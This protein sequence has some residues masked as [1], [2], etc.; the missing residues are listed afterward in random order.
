VNQVEFR[1]VTDLEA[2]TLRTLEA[3][4]DEVRAWLTEALEPYRS[5][6]ITE[7]AISDG[8]AARAKINRLSKA[9]SDQRIAVKKRYLE[10]Y[11][12][13][14]AKAK[15]LCAICD[16]ASGHIDTQIKEI[17]ERRKQE[18]LEGL[19]AYF[20]ERADQAEG[21]LTWDDVFNPKWGNAGFGAE[22]AQKEIE[23][24][25]S[26]CEADMA[27]IREMD[28]PHQAALIAHY[29]ATHDI[30]AVIRKDA[31]LKRVEAAE[32]ERRAAQE[33]ARREAESRRAEQERMER[34]RSA[35]QAEEETVEI[36]MVVDEEDDTPPLDVDE[37][38]KEPEK[39][40]NQVDFRVWA[41][42]AQLGLL[43]RFLRENGIKYGRV[44]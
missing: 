42:D 15:E 8:K 25:I 20:Q 35:A 44:I 7:E 3:N 36:E 4:F 34:E 32:Q 33:A 16:D 38:K 43:A 31:E 12:E 29:I 39:P 37:S 23:T 21:C 11:T 17:E 6:A 5:L 40:L 19:R 26:A 2:A 22:A 1:L 24:R 41:T 27:A 13:F 30:G 9:I 28:S 14:E 18:K 10:P